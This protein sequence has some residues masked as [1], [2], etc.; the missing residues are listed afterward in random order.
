[1]RGSSGPAYRSD[2]SQQTPSALLDGA[3]AAAAAD[4]AGSP[5]AADGRGHPLIVAAAAA[6]DRGPGERGV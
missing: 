6:A 2:R 4:M 3:E 5:L 1:M